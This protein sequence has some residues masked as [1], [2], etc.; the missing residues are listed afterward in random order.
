[1]IK[2]DLN[3]FSFNPLSGELKTN[4]AVNLAKQLT[5]LVWSKNDKSLFAV[6]VETNVI[7]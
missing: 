4:Q 3:D 1:M 2:V 5:N 6:G 7:S